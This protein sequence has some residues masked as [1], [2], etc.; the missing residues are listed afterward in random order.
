M[1][2]HWHLYKRRESSN[3]TSK[4]VQLSTRI[5]VFFSLTSPKIGWLPEYDTHLEVEVALYRYIPSRRGQGLLRA[6]SAIGPFFSSSLLA[7]LNIFPSLSCGLILLVVLLSSDWNLGLA[8]STKKKVENFKNFGVLPV[9]NI[10]SKLSKLATFRGYDLEADKELSYRIPSSWF[11]RFKFHRI[12]EFTSTHSSMFFLRSGS[13]CLLLFVEM[14]EFE[15]ERDGNQR[16]YVAMRAF[17]W[18]S[19]VLL[20]PIPKN[21]S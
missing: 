9:V 14:F 17:P 11:S 1:A 20:F 5:N 10:L 18:S 16:L 12:S 7:L 13:V 6:P 2:T 4:V 19:R 8:C 15:F 3:C 21:N